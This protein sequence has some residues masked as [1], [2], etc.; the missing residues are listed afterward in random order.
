MTGRAG[1]RRVIRDHPVLTGLSALALLVCVLFL[2]RLGMLLWTGGPDAWANRPV[3]DWMTP[4]FVIRVYDIAPEALAEVFGADPSTLRGQPLRD[5]ARAQGLTLPDLM[6]A[7]DGL[8][9]Q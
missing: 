1:L 2:M 8:R 5:I 9:T 6:R 7:I 4:G 3:E